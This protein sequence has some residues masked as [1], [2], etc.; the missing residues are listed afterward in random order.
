MEERTHSHRYKVLNEVFD[1]VIKSMHD[2]SMVRSNLMAFGLREEAKHI[3]ESLE[4]L[5]KTKTMI[6]QE[7]FNYEQ[8]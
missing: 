5:T 2:L 4:E 1:V 3:T 7:I 6:L 8:T